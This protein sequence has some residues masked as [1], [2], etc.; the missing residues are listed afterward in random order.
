MEKDCKIVL[1][2]HI[3]H[4]QQQYLA[5]FVALAKNGLTGP[6]LYALF[7]RWVPFCF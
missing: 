6:A 5:I 2:V 4:N 1:N 3:G 7:C